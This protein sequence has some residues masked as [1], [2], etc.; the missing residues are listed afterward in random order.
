MPLLLGKNIPGICD[1]CG[2]KV[3]HGT[4][5]SE[6]ERGKDKGNMVCDECFDGDH[7]Q[8]WVG[9]TPVSDRQSVRDAQPEPNLRSDRSL[10]GFNPVGAPGNYLILRTGIVSILIS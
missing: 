5:S 8:N 1:R 3:I 2:R 7:P 6:V 10:Y 9:M 4:L